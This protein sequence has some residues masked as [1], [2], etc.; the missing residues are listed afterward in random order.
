MSAQVLPWR[1][2]PEQDELFGDENFGPART[3]K[4]TAPILALGTNQVTRLVTRAIREG[5]DGQRHA[6]KMLAQAVNTNTR[7]AKN[8]LDGMNMPNF[9]DGLR[10]AAQIPELKALV[11]DLI[12]AE[13][14]MPP[15]FEKK[16]HALMREYWQWREVKQ[17]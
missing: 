8:W 11:M 14:A 6:A 9:V 2:V 16:F 12:G 3:E 7:T 15:V 1:S 17:Q 13:D 5:H 4:V 10:L